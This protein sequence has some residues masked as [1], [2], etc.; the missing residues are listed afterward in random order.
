LVAIIPVLASYEGTTWTL[1][2]N[3]L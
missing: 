2:P 1:V 3:F